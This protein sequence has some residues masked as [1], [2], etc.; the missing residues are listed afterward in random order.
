[1]NADFLSWLLNV[2]TIHLSMSGGG[3]LLLYE[4]PTEYEVA[5]H[6]SIKV[7]VNTRMLST[8]KNEKYI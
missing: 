2:V 1:M 6:I 5:E 7:E 4:N 3:R 8:L